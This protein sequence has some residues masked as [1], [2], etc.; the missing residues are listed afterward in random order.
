MFSFL[1]C[2][3]I[4]NRFLILASFLDP[5]FQSLTASDDS[6]SIRK[7]LEKGLENNEIKPEPKVDEKVLKLKQ[8]KG[9]RLSSLFSNIST[10]TKSKA[11]KNRFDIEFRSYTEDVT[12]DI[13]LCPLEWWS[14]SE[15]LYPTIKQHV[16]KYFCVPSFVNNFHRL[17]LREQEELEYKYDR[18]ANETNEKLLWLHLNELRQRSS[19]A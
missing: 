7:E 14:E 15:S 2:S 3:I 6:V 17:P 8:E 9:F 19:E 16:K 13:E 1:F 4:E 10:P 12:L 11:P 18:I 5:R